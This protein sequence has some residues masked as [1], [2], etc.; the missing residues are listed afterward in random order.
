MPYGWLGPE[1]P[2]NPLCDACSVAN[3]EVEAIEARCVSGGSRGAGEY[4]LLRSGVEELGPS[5]AM[6]S[7]PLGAWPPF[8]MLFRG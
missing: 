6:V 1:L 2:A 5:C 8:T 3:D 7:E 4:V